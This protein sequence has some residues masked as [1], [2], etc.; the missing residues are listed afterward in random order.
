MLRW[1]C[2]DRRF[3]LRRRLRDRSGLSLLSGLRFGNWCVLEEVVTQRSFKIGD[4]LTHGLCLGHAESCW[5]GVSDGLK[6]GWSMM[7]S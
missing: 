1:G 2:G 5:S 4:E 7:G 3:N 6:F